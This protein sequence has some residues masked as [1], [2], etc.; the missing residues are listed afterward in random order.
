MVYDLSKA[1]DTGNIN[2][3][4]NNFALNEE[5]LKRIADFIPNINWLGKIIQILK[6]KLYNNCIFVLFVIYPKKISSAI[7]F[8]INCNNLY[9]SLFMEMNIF[10]IFE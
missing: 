9:Q 8:F 6:P 2:H 7:K 10:I 4:A 5:Q 1:F 3:L